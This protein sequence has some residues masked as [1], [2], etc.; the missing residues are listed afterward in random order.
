MQVAGGAPYGWSWSGGRLGEV[1]SEQRVIALLKRMSAEGLSL[2]QIAAALT[3]WGVR[4][5]RGKPKW[6]HI[7]VK[8]VL[9]F[10]PRGCG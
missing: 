10:D 4:T 8:N 2:S 7:T 9:T 1:A 6:F 5:K 3:R